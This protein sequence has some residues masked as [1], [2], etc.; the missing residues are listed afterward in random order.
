MQPRVQRGHRVDKS[1][2]VWLQMAVCVGSQEPMLDVVERVRLEADRVPS[3][4]VKALPP[5]KRRR[6]GQNK[7]RVNREHIVEVDEE[8]HSPPQRE[9]RNINPLELGHSAAELCKLGRGEEGLA[10]QSPPVIPQEPPVHAHHFLAQICRNDAC[11]ARRRNENTAHVEVSFFVV[12]DKTINDGVGRVELQLVAP[13]ELLVV[14]GHGTGL[15]LRVRTRCRRSR[16]RG[17]VDVR[18]LLPRSD[19]ADDVVPQEL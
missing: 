7:H 13:M 19:H 8:R 16:V 14:V 1:R 6:A 18:V 2:I 3:A 10:V 11:V 9:R 12:D 5:Q 17:A 4:L 15:G